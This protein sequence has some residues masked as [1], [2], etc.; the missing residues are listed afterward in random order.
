MIDGLNAQIERMRSS[1]RRLPIVYQGEAADCGL[2]CLAMVASYF[3]R[4]TDLEDVKKYF[5]VSKRGMTVESIMLVAENLGMHARPLRAELE[6]LRDA[7]LPA[8]LHWDM[9]H[10]VVLSAINKDSIDIIDP[11]I[12]EKKVSWEEV[13]E[14]FTGILIEFSTAADFS[15]LTKRNDFSIADLVTNQ[16]GLWSGLAKAVFL[17]LL[18]QFTVLGLPI[19]MQ[20]SVDN[21]IYTEDLAGLNLIALGIFCLAV[22]TLV[23]QLVRGLLLLHLG[24]LLSFQLARNVFSHMLRL[25]ISFF[26]KRDIGDLISRMNSLVPIKDFLTTGVPAVV[27]DGFMSLSTILLMFYFSVELS[28]IA[29]LGVFIYFSVRWIYLSKEKL[30]EREHLVAQADETSSFID[31][32]NAVSSIKL[33]GKEKS[34]QAKWENKFTLTINKAW[35][36]ER[37]SELMKALLQFTLN[38]ETIAIVY[39]GVVL[40][41]RDDI[42]VGVL[43]AFLALRLNFSDRSKALVDKWAEYKLTNVHTGRLKD[44]VQSKKQSERDNIN[45]DKDIRGD[46]LVRDVSFSY[47]TGEPRIFDKCK[48]AIKGGAITA[49]VGPSG[50]GKT[51]LFKLLIGILQPSV[52]SISVGGVELTERNIISFRRHV[53]VVSQDDRLLRGSLAEN[54]AFFDERIDMDLVVQAAGLACVHDDI[55]S[56]PMGYETLVGELGSGLSGGQLQRVYLARALYRKPDILFVDEGTSSLDLE[57]EQKINANLNR[58]HLTRVLVAHRPNT[59]SFADRVLVV[60]GQKVTEVSA[61]EWSKKMNSIPSQ[62]DHESQEA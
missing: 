30:L 49:I 33:F 57:T 26:E 14:R 15:K 17:S 11:A 35:S 41:G 2:A 27:I 59:V 52:G 12:G 39:F 18:L 47:G 34:Q 28:L 29:I 32:L 46:I 4:D 40:I 61:G 9:N 42:S 13:D 16:R 44:I 53:A 37:I 5:T 60:D 58:M 45:F 21:F 24:Q 1:G 22:V 50:A 3:G 38:L 23:T 55:S 48:C 36:I 54:I 62:E 31:V 43:I 25:P 10:F 20:F 8:V 56:M 51:T 7:E 6:Y 19:Y